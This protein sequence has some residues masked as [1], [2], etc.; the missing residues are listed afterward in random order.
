MQHL[1][2]CLLKIWSPQGEK[3]NFSHPKTWLKVIDATEPGQSALYDPEPIIDSMQALRVSD[4]AKLIFGENEDFVHSDKDEPLSDGDAQANVTLETTTQRKRRS[5]VAEH[6]TTPS[7]SISPKRPKNSPDADHY[8]SAMAVAPQKHL[9]FN[10]KDL[11]LVM[12]LLA[13]PVKHCVLFICLLENCGELGE[14]I[15]GCGN[16]YYFRR[17]RIFGMHIYIGVYIGYVN[18]R[19]IPQIIHIINYT[20]L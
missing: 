16:D 6:N 13:I 9:P 7:S 20:L 10:S 18:Y 2:Y 8:I 11:Q 5:P 15:S 17:F 4:L 19:C 1:N 14:A 12:A 3:N